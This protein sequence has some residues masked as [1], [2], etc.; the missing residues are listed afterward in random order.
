MCK[1]ATFASD[2]WFKIKSTYDGYEGWLT[3][4]LIKQIETTTALNDASFI[5]TER[6]NLLMHD[7]EAIYLP[8]GSSLVGFDKETNLL[9]D[10]SYQYHGVYRN[11]NTPLEDQL[12]QKTVFAWRNAPYLWGGKTFMG[13][14][15][16]GFVQIVFKVL[17]IKLFRDANQQATQGIVIESLI[18]TKEGDLAFFQNGNGKIIHVGILLNDNKIIHASGRVKIDTI[19]EEGIIDSESGN[20]THQLHSMKKFF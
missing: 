19:D 9:W 11:I 16:S 7:A 20:R 18:E 2:E 12:L 10:E 3:H 6:D 1:F 17:G 8:M 13:V 15:C 14:D 5:T 4:H